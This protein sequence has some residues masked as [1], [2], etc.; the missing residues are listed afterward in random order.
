MASCNYPPKGRTFRPERYLLGLLLFLA[1]FLSSAQTSVITGVVK[2]TTGKPIEGVSVTVSGSKTGVATDAMGRFTLNNVPKG[3]KLKVTS[4]NYEDATITTGAASNYTIVLQPGDTKLESVVVV[5]YAT[6]KKANLTGSVATVSAKQMADRPVTNISSALSGLMPGVYARQGSGDPRGDGASIQI[7]GTGTLSSNAPLVLVDGIIGVMDAVNP[8]DVE[9]ITVLK[10]AASASIYGTLAANGVIL[11][12]TKKGQKGRLTVNYSGDMSF[13]NPMNLPKFITNYAAHMRLVNE[14]YVNVG[15]PPVFSQNTINAW[16]SASKIPNQ[17]NAIGVPNYIA[18]PNVDQAHELFSNR[19]SQTHTVSINGGSDKVAY[20]LSL[21]YLNNKGTIANTGIERYQLRA[22]LDARVNKFITLGT[23]TFASMQ[24]SEMAN[25]GSA[26]NFLNQTTPGVVPYWNGRYG[27]PQAPEESSTANNIRAY[28]YGTGGD[29]QTTRFNTTVYANFNI[30]KGLTLEN[31]I[32]YQTR[33]NEYNS[34]TNPDP[35][36]RWNFATNEMK[37]GLPSLTTLTTYYSY[38]KNTQVTIDNV[39]RYTTQIGRDH[40]IS[41][42]AGYNQLYYTY[43]NFNATKTGL[44]DYS[45]TTPGSAL[46]PTTI[47]G[48]KYDYA[49]RSWFGRLNYGYKGRYLLEGNLRYDGVSRFSPETRWGLFPSVSAGWRI[50]EEHFMAS[51]KNWLSNLKLRASW[52]KLGNNASGNYDWQATYS[53]SLYSFANTQVSGLAVGNYANRGLQWETTTNTNIGLEGAVLQN[54]LFFEL[55]VYRR[56][57]NGILT[58]API[59]LTAGTASAPVVNVAEV[60]NKGVELNIGY[61]TRIG[62]LGISV[63]GNVAYNTNMVT[64]Y[65]G[66][67]VEGWVKDANGNNVYQTNLGAVS[68]GD[69]TRRLEGHRIDEYYLYKVYHGSGNYFNAD[70][71]VDINGGPKDGM[72]RTPKDKAWADAMI[73]AGHPLRPANGVRN[74]AIWY[75][76]LVYADINSDGDY[77]NSFDRYFT[78]TSS[79]PKVIFGFSTN[80]TWKQFDL[81]MI[82]AGAAGMQYYWNDGYNNATVRNGFAITTLV[83]ND[84]YF[85]DPNNPSDPRTNINAKYPRLKVQGNDPQ[86]SSVASDFWLYNASWIKLKNLQVG[87]NLPEKWTRKAYLQRA[88]VYFSGEN[89][90]LITKFPGLD[91]EIGSSVGYPT[92]RQFSLGV[93]LTF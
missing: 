36:V 55:D 12:T 25:A 62:D 43:Y 4:V 92:M 7:R 5:G 47:N 29:D 60:T 88:R 72:I 27:F 35:S 20:L 73:A 39:L 26:F 66:A 1:P 34:H 53:N 80:F 2:D 28:L 45:I 15:Q 81:S 59:P 69:V 85:Y 37:A 58:S 83:A 91:P 65:K 71:S 44:V 78:G 56:V 67:L 75:G 16:D 38:D 21:G 68:T 84:H 19:L 76:D 24:T 87:Y 42:L 82:W 93:N 32:N 51:T 77:G 64:A 31:R 46:T 86:N 90:L 13:T 11:I 49:I 48:D 9:S 3:S 70:G 40:D 41:A 74:T 22:N 30:I 89:L 8:L 61:K 79:Q 63:A 23:Q 57:T 50:S 54:K 52:G 10:D 14:G 18:Y 6:Q 33:Q 17:L